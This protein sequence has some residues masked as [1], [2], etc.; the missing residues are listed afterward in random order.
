MGSSTLIDIVSS[1][2]ISGL[3]LLVAIRMDEKSIRNTFDSQASLTVQQNLTSLVESLEYDFRKIG[4][5]RKPERLPSADEPLFIQ[6]GDT[7]SISFLTDVAD[8]G[9]VDTVKYWLGNTPIAGCPNTKVRML[10]RKVNSGPAVGSNLGITQF[11][12]RY[13]NT[14]GDTLP[15]TP[16]VAPSQVQVI[17]ITIRVEPTAAYDT[18]YSSN[19]AVWRQTRLVSRN[20][21]R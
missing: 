6:Q 15:P 8:T 11:Y 5:C 1:M 2:L 10:Y 18:A 17:E 19:Y 12:L 14:S 13:I 3:L 7:S 4:Y 9:S 21:Q 20:L 16:F